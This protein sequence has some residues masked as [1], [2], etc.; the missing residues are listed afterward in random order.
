M[1][2]RTILWSG[3]CGAL[4]LIPGMGSAAEGSARSLQEVLQA[5]SPL[6]AEQF[7]SVSDSLPA[8][9]SVMKGSWPP[10]SFAAAR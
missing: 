10:D 1:R 4:I 3:W 6:T 9:S 8:D 5:K 7:K 2:N